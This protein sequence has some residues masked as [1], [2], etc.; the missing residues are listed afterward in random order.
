MSSS[1]NAKSK[2]QRQDISETRGRVLGQSGPPP[3]KV[4]RYQNASSALDPQSQRSETSQTGQNAKNK[5]KFA[6]ENVALGKRE[7]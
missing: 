3:P 4:P 1:R 7:E 6:A 5:T 2:R